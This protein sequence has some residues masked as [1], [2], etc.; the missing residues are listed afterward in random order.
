MS[1]KKP[2]KSADPMSEPRK[3]LEKWILDEDR[4]VTSSYLLRNTELDVV[5]VEELMQS[6]LSDNLAKNVIATYFI[7]G[8]IRDTEAEDDGVAAVYKSLVCNQ[9]NLEKTKA[10]FEAIS[11][12]S[13]YSLQ[14][15]PVEDYAILYNVRHEIEGYPYVMPSKNKLLFWQKR[16][17][18]IHTR[19]EESRGDVEKLKDIKI[20]K[21]MQ[22]EM[23]ENAQKKVTIDNEESDEEP[24]ERGENLIKE[25]AEGMAVDEGTSAQGGMFGSNMEGIFSTGIDSSPEKDVQ[26]GSKAKKS[27]PPKKRKSQGKTSG[28]SKQSM[29]RVI[30]SD[31]DDEEAGVEDRNKIMEEQDEQIEQEPIAP[32]Q[33]QMTTSYRKEMV[34]ES[35]VDDD[36][37]TVT[38]MVPK[39][40]EMEIESVPQNRPTAQGKSVLKPSNATNAKKPA[41]VGKTNPN[42]PKIS[43][44]FT[45]K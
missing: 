2:T 27:P 6:F 41:K 30:D 1:P 9:Q 43:N 20:K 17:D 29:R 26:Q 18:K 11:T 19:W 8:Q 35:F 16:T 25:T 14:A 10:M 21:M 33:S 32:Q 31:E 22:D 42:Q 5:Q 13:L 7:I 40:V 12:C 24:M 3:K 23:M 38:R 28:K 15:K 45:K 37:Y 44:F 39:L 36:G 4:I 34:S